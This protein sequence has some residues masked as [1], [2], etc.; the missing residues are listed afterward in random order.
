MSP[1]AGHLSLDTIARLCEGLLPEMEQCFAED[2][3]A[4]CEACRG[5]LE[6]MDALLYRGFSAESHAAAIR[7]EA[8]AA[9][10]LVVALR[11]TVGRLSR[12]AGVAVQRWLSSAAAMWDAGT[13]PVF[14]SLGAVPVSGEDEP[15]PLRVALERGTTRATIRIAEAFRQIEV[16]VSGEAQPML[17]VLFA[18]ESDFAPAVAAFEVAGGVRLARFAKVPHG[19]YSL[20]IS[21]L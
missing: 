6:R 2:H 20:A 11:E 5:T 15:L 10:P 4:E 19:E 18:S 14:G 8:Y 3:L 12:E 1:Q 9:D 17:A 16:E 13:A 7:R 21:P